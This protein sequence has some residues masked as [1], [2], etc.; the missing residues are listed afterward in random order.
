MSDLIV[1]GFEASKRITAM[2]S[3]IT[4][5]SDKE[6]RDLI[7]KTKGIFEFQIKNA[8]GNEQVWT[9]DMKKDGHIYKGRAQPKCDV[10]IIVSDETFVALADG[11]LDG[12]TAFMTGKLKTKGN[13]MLA[14]KL[15]PVLATAKP[16]AKL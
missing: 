11:K 13:M 4:A 16:K 6:K 8:D 15:G 2:A 7:K 10:T 3:A 14:T 12:Q 9:I 1:P 5:L